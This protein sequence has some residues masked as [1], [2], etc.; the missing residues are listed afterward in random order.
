MRAT[1]RFAV[2]VVALTLSVAV[3][4]SACTGSDQGDEVEGVASSSQP[5]TASTVTPV[6]LAVVPNLALAPEQC[7]AA[8]DSVVTTPTTS[9]PSAPANTGEAATSTTGPGSTTEPTS[10]D[11]LPDTTV[12]ARPAAVAVVDC[13][14]GHEG[15]V[16]A[17]FCLGTDEDSDGELTSVACPGDVDLPY[18][19]DRNIRR[20]AARVCLQRFEE[21]FAETYASSARVAREF[22]PNEG[23]WSLGDHRVV[24]HTTM[25]EIE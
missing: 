11:T 17:A 24:C 20:A 5:P 9:Q 12:V 18:P 13:N 6:L 10:P 3:L 14:G 7:F 2:R 21:T 4:L 16:Y 25:A 15:R 1:R 22:T 8:V 19:G 23:V